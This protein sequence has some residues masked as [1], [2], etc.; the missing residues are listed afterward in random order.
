MCPA[1]LKRDLS[2]H[3]FTG[4]LDQIDVILEGVGPL[5]EFKTLLYKFFVLSS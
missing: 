2:R 4:K 1:G 3:K 5:W